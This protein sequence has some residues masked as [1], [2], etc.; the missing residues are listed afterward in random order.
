[1]AAQ[2]EE[3]LRNQIPVFKSEIEQIGATAGAVLQ[4][5]DLAFDSGRNAWP[6][7][8][9]RG[10]APKAADAIA[11]PDDYSFSTNAM[12]LFALRTLLGDFQHSIIAIAGMKPTLSWSSENV[13]LL[14]P[15]LAR[16]DQDLSLIHI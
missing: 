16:A 6:Y 15:M 3:Y 1:V 8:L 12:V 7:R 5:F 10:K 4:S 14:T 9:D 13:G 2:L 11:D